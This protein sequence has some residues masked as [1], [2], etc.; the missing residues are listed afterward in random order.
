[1]ENSV[2]FGRFFFFFISVILNKI[3]LYNITTSIAMPHFK[4]ESF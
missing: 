1:M 3:Q 4:D 2:I